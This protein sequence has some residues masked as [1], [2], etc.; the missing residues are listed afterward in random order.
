MSMPP[1]I[2]FEGGQSVNFL[3]KLPQEIPL[4]VESPFAKINSD[5]IQYNVILD[6]NV[7]S[8]QLAYKQKLS[9]LRELR[10]KLANGEP[11][12]EIA[13]EFEKSGMSSDD[14]TIK[15]VFRKDEV[16]KIKK[17]IQKDQ[18]PQV[19]IAM[20]RN[21]LLKNQAQ[22]EQILKRASHDQLTHLSPNQD[23]AQYSKFHK[24]LKYRVI[25]NDKAVHSKLNNYPTQTDYY[26]KI[27]TP[28]NV[29]QIFTP[30]SFC[31]LIGLTCFTYVNLP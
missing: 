5:Q 24:D 23:K 15:D 3:Q 4:Q 11:A 10:N 31:G 20:L 26:T 29:Q 22:Y 19:Q 12:L 6:L 9:L 27:Y 16:E 8:K 7:Q 30:Q 17:A 28:P 21:Q 13:D 25:Q 18:E 2:Y 1:K 14:K